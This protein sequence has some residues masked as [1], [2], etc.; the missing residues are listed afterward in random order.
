MYT[1]GVRSILSRE[2]GDTVYIDL[3]FSTRLTGYAIYGVQVVR[4]LLYGH[5]QSK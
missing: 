1:F 2:H 3:Q 5:A 4:H